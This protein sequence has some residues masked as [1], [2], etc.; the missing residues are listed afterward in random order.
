MFELRIS[1]KSDF[2]RAEVT[3]IKFCCRWMAEMLVEKHQIK[4]ALCPA[5]GEK[6]SPYIVV[7]LLPSEQR[8]KFC[9][10]CGKPIEVEEVE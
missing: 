4:I 9:P 5:E 1:H 2:E 10:F 7:A 3:V 8:F 6:F